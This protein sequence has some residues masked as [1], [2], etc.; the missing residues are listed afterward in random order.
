MRVGTF[1]GAAYVLRATSFGSPLIGTP[2]NSAVK[3]TVPA[4]RQYGWRQRRNGPSRA[5]T[6]TRATDA[7][8]L[9][10]QGPSSALA[11]VGLVIG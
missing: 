9:S 5:K 7:L 10:N 8:L 2:W 4:R 1:T 11:L 6:V 3:G